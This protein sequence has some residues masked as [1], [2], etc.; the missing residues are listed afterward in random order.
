M[1]IKTIDNAGFSGK[2]P[3]KDV[4]YIETVDT[5]TIF[6]VPILATMTQQYSDGIALKDTEEILKVEVDQ[7]PLTLVDYAPTHPNHLVK[8][9]TFEK[10]DVIVGMMSE[11]SMSKTRSPTKRYADFILFK[12]PKINALIDAYLSGSY[13]DTS[14]GFYSENDHTPGE[15]LGQKYDYIQRNIKLDHNTILIDRNGNRSTGRMPSP[16][17]GIGA[18][19]NNGGHTMSDDLKKQ[20]DAMKIASDEAIANIKAENQKQI[21]ALKKD[22]EETIATLNKEKDALKKKVGSI[23]E[24]EKIKMLSA[25]LETSKTD[26]DKT[27]VDMKEV[28]DELKVAQDSLKVFTDKEEKDLKVKVDA[29]KALHPEFADLFDKAD[30]EY[31]NT[32]YDESQKKDG[33]SKDIGADMMRVNSAAAKTNATNFN[34]VYGKKKPKGDE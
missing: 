6:N 4:D 33:N 19:S 1:V 25:D 29:L 12:T 5:F 15:F 18:D 9:N 10:K 16:I 28:K 13:I 14:I 7:V 23:D 30:A 31:I 3:V 32:K 27:K 2:V 21:D 26:L 24:E 8:S 34:K 11:P 22:N 17:G 20:M